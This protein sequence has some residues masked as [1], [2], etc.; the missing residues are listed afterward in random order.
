MKPG[1]LYRSRWFPLS[2]EDFPTSVSP[3][4]HSH[5]SHNLCSLILPIPATNVGREESK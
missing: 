4:L 5:P 1:L 2:D 3:S